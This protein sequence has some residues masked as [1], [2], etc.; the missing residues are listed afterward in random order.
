MSE[1]TFLLVWEITENADELKT[2]VLNVLDNLTETPRH[3]LHWLASRAALAEYFGQTTDITILKN[4]FNKPSM[5]VNN[6]PYHLSIT[7]SYKYA[8]VL[9][10]TTH[11][12]AV[13]LEK[14]DDRIARVSQ[15][16]VNAAEA[17]MF[18]AN[19]SPI[20]FQTIIWSAKETLYKHYG[21][22]ELDFKQHLTV[23]I[24]QTVDG[25]KLRGCIH[26]TS[27]FFYEMTMMPLHNYVLT[28]LIEK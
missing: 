9:F 7:H 21:Q 6:V 16:F 18:L 19:N 23:F 27:V 5:L 25:I 3:N 26:K 22:K 10:S 12:V 14:V 2:K 4:E 24:T 15:K 1:N 28:Y 13:D 17:E 11:K 20:L 8:A